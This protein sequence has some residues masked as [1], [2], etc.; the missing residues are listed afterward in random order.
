MRFMRTLRFISFVVFGLVVVPWSGLMAATPSHVIRLGTLAPDG[1]PLT[2]AYKL[3]DHELKERSGGEVRLR[4]YAGGAAG[5]EKVMVR[6][7]RAGQL[8]GAVLT[9]TGLGAL[10]RQVLVLQAP[11]VIRNYRQ[12]DTVRDAMVDEFAAIFEQEGYSLLGWGDAG[13][14]RL[15]SK[16]PIRVPNDLKQMRP[17]VWRDS[18]VMVELIRSIGANGVPLGVPEVYPGLQTGMIDS[19]MASSMTAIGFQWAARVRYM[20]DPPAGVIVGAIVLRKETLESLPAE[21]RAHFASRIAA[22]E[23]KARSSAR[24]MDRR[25]TIELKKRLTII[26]NEPH[27]AEWERAAK[28]AK[29]ALTGRLYSKALLDRVEALAASAN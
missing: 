15:F 28:K 23:A 14:L 13:E 12:L 17:W 3:L 27:R 24:D 29:D 20:T 26:D 16:E 2:K 4:L 6:K 22:A 21:I 19:V 7:M 8:D 9:T 11:G 5:D 1:T 10:V 25:A 18:P